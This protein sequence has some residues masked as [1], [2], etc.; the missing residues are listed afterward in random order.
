MRVTPGG[1]RSRT[2]WTRPIRRRTRDVA[3]VSERVSAVGRRSPTLAITS[4]GSASACRCSRCAT[5][6]VAPGCSATRA[7][8]VGWRSS[9]APGCAHALVCRYHGWT[10]RLDGSLSHVPHADAFPDL[11]VA[12]RG[13][14]EVHS[15]EVDGL[16]VIGPCSSATSAPGHRRAMTALT[17]GSPWRD[18]LLPVERLVYVD[19][20]CAADELEGSRRAVPRGLPHPLDTQGHVLPDA[21]RRPQRRRTI[22]A[23]Q[24]N[25]VP[26]SEHRA[27]ARPPG[28]VVE[29]RQT[30]RRSSTTCS[31]TSCSRRSPTRS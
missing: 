28:V 21:V 13:L 7:A 19:R 11:D 6:T 17:D 5:A 2:T 9:R 18:K 31:R 12:T 8:T 23:E 22:R 3:L 14:V 30:G 26:L 25:H 15:H 1:S 24:P 20:H 27:T 16:I 10:Y 4:S 29:H